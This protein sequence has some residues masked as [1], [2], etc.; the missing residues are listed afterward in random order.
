MSAPQLATELDVS[1]PTVYRRIEQLDAL[2]LLEESTEIDPDGHHRSVYRARLDRIT[3]ELGEE[4]FSVTVHRDDHP[5]DSLTDMW[6][7]I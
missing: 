5:A 2:D 7:G 4:E 3:V 6:E 1:H